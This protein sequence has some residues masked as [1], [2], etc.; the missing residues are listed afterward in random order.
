[1][2]V[3]SISYYKLV[4]FCLIRFC[5][6]LEGDRPKGIVQEILKALKNRDGVD[7]TVDMYI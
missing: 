1:M 6:G 7:N 2:K 5:F 3:E 4:W